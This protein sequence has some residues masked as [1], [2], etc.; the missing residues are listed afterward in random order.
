MNI[1][2]LISQIKQKQGELAENAVR[3]PTSLEHYHRICGQ[4]AGLQA[5]FDLIEEQLKDTDS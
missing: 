3:L 2:K 4:W 5:A 1:E